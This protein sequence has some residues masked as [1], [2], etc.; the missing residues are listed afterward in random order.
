MR[1]TVTGL[2]IHA[3]RAGEPRIRDAPE[4]MR[5]NIQRLRRPSGFRRWARCRTDQRRLAGWAARLVIVSTIQRP[6][7]FWVNYTPG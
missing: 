2:S 4:H 6:S 1:P 5:A 7:V 3:H